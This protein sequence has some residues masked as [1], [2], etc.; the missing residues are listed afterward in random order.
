MKKYYVVIIDDDGSKLAEE[1]IRELECE[2]GADEIF[3][4]DDIKLIEK[5][6]N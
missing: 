4:A 6:V 5:I 1:T 2:Y 3:D